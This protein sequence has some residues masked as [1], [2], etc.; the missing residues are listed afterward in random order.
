MTSAR[1]TRPKDF[2]LVRFWT[3]SSRAYEVGIYRD[4]ALL[5]VSP[6]GFARL[7]GYFGATVAD[8]VRETAQPPARDGWRQ[9]E[10]PIESVDQAAIDFLK[11]GAD[12]EVLKPVELRRHI[13]RTAREMAKLNS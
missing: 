4:K 7:E 10:V 1:F 5:R 11:L 6:R 8:A 2:D 3:E 9:V 13:A 12:A